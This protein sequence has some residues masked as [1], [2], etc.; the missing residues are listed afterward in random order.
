MDMTPPP[1]ILSVA[2]SVTKPERCS[3]EKFCKWYGNQHV[4]KVVA[5]SGVSG[6]VRY[7]ALPYFEVVVSGDGAGEGNVPDWFGR[8]MWLMI[9]EMDVVEFRHSKEFMGLYGVKGDFA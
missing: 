5:L 6:A 1:G 4:D 3:K 9:Y 2:S 8:A 7:E